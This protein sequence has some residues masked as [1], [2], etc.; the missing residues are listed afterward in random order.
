MK[1]TTSYDRRD[2][3]SVVKYWLTTAVTA[4]HWATVKNSLAVQMHEQHRS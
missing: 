3:I 4:H 1:S 2:G